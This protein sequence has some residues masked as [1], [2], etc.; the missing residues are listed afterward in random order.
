[1]CISTDLVMHSFTSVQ[2]GQ[3]IHVYVCVRPYLCKYCVDL[4][5]QSPTKVHVL[6]PLCGLCGLY[7]Y[8]FVWCIHLHVHVS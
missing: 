1:M 6:P 5:I 8:V 3:G 2:K 7:V 4:S